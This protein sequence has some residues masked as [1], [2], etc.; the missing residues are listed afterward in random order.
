MR[1]PRC[2]LPMI[3]PA[4]SSSGIILLRQ[5]FTGCHFLRDISSQGFHTDN[6]GVDAGS[7]AVVGTHAIII[8]LASAQPGHAS[9]GDVA[10][11]EVLISGY[12]TA[13]GTASGHIQLIARGSGYTR[14]VSSEPAL[15]NA[16]GGGGRRRCQR[17]YEIIA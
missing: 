16:R 2:A 14:P 4:L 7:S 1:K 17:N 15:G 6:V 11:V 3:S 5:T 9:A 8:G 13:K 10:H 12:V